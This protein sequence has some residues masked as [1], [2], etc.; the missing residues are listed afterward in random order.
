MHRNLYDI[1]CQEFNRIQERQT[2][3]IKASEITS[4]QTCSIFHQLR[5]YL[6][7]HTLEYLDAL[8]ANESSILLQALGIESSESPDISLAVHQLSLAMII[9]TMLH[10]CF[11]KK[12]TCSILFHKLCWLDVSSKDVH[13]FLSRTKVLWKWSSFDH[14]LLLQN[15]IDVDVGDPD[16]NLTLLNFAVAY[17]HIKQAQM[18]IEFGVSLEVDHSSYNNH[19]SVAWKWS[20]IPCSTM[21]KF[22]DLFFSSS[23]QYHNTL[24]FNKLIEMLENHKSHRIDEI[25]DQVYR[26]RDLNLKDRSNRS[27]LFYAST[28]PILQMLMYHGLKYTDYEVARC[29]RS[30]SIDV[31][32]F[33]IKDG[34]DFNLILQEIHTQVPP[35][36]LKG[37]LVTLHN[38]KK[39]YDDLLLIQLKLGLPTVCDDLLKMVLKFV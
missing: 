12:D 2:S 7:R 11:S 31:L 13:W 14:L 19:S 18:L 34:A 35:P 22:Y 28:V 1:A 4:V 30:M 33:I 5:L 10:Y 24:A 6:D 21:Q 38:A 39:Q 20:E 3:L 29:I 23:V 32:V 15:W 16:T 36:Y 25:I 27:L 9:T 26:T 17:K 8:K 37:V